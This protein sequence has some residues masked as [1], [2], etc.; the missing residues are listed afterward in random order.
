MAYD[1]CQVLKAYGLDVLD[2][3]LK[4]RGLVE[5]QLALVKVIQSIPPGLG[6]REGE[7]S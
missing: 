1:V 4:G 6:G 5:V 2:E 3:S 7:E